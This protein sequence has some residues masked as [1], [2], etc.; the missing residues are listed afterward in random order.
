MIRIIELKQNEFKMCL[1]GYMNIKLKNHISANL[2]TIAALDSIEN[3]LKLM[4]SR[5]V[6]HLPVTDEQGIIIGLVSDRDLLK[7][8]SQKQLHICDVMTT[9]LKKVDV[10]DDIQDV[11]RRMVDSK[12]SAIPVT[13]DSEIIGIVTTE[14]LMYLLLKLLDESDDGPTLLTDFVESFKGLSES[15][16]YP[17]YIT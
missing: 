13:R 16:K 5:A 12:I 2:I 9:Q 17:N 4:Q 3:G 14:D 6:R 7:G 8:L 11:I 1:G 15:F 10:N